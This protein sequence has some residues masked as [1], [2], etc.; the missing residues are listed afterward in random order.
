LSSEDAAALA[1]AFLHDTLA[2]ALGL[3]WER[4]TLVHPRGQAPLLEGLLA[5]RVHL[6]EQPSDGLGDALAYA[7]EWH[8]SAGFNSVTLI[9]SD[10]P[11]W[12]GEPIQAAA[13]ALRS[14]DDVAIGPASDGGYYLIGMRQPHLRLFE[15]IDWS[16]SRVFTQTLM[17]ADE[18]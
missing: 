4:T 5:P 7:F 11:T 14:D 18:L 15:R 6:L 17:R 8:F 3:R 10:T 2:T 13:D 1:T 16:T 9:G 12:P